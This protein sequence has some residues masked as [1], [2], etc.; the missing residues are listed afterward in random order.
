MGWAT[1]AD[2]LLSLLHRWREEATKA[3]CAIGRMCVAYEAGRDGFWLAR[4]LRARGIE[5][6]V[7]HAL[8]AGFGARLS[9][10]AWWRSRR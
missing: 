9:I 3:G 10:A 6:Y 5:A 8:W 1:G 4:W 7:M 2:A